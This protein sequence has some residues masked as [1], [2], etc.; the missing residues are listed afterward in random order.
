[1]AKDLIARLHKLAEAFTDETDRSKGMA[2]ILNEIAEM[3]AQI[4]ERAEDGAL[5]TR[6]A[7]DALDRI[8]QSAEELEKLIPDGNAGNTEDVKNLA[9]DTLDEIING[10]AVAEEAQGSLEELLSS[11]DNMST[12]IEET[13]ELTREQIRNMEEL[14]E[15]M[16]H[17]TD[18]D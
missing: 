14:S 4:K 1:M 15:S 9:S 17:I 7:T 16:E 6:L 8:K 11:V 13:E 18:E 3:L 5:R 2:D 12:M 10:K